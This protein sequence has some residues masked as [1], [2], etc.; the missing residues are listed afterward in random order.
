MLYYNVYIIVLLVYIIVYPY[1]CYMA[2]SNILL[3]TYIL[4]VASK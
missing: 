2:Y 4:Y 1:P 3:L